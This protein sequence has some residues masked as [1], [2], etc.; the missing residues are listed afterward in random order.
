MGKDW[1]RGGGS[2]KRDEEEQ[3]GNRSMAATRV[4]GEWTVGDDIP[5]PSRSCVQTTSTE[6]VRLR[7]GHF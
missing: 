1:G 5:E 3:H 4:G 6:L 2:R 7:P